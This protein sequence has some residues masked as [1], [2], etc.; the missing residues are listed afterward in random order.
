[1]HARRP[2]DSQKKQEAKAPGGT[3]TKKI[4]IKSSPVNFAN[5]FQRENQYVN[6]QYVNNSIILYTYIKRYIKDYFFLHLVK[7]AQVRV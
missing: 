1:M 2:Y 3:N 4:K 7:F 6:N 5:I